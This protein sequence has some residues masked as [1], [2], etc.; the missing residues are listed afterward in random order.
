MPAAS[1]L[2]AL[3]ASGATSIVE[4][5]DRY[6]QARPRT[7][8][9]IV[10]SDLIGVDSEKLDRLFARLA[11]QRWRVVL[12]HIEDPME[13]DPADLAEAHEVLEI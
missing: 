8:V 10:V 3:K 1:Y 13:A 4:S 12:I 9:L 5:V 2:A 11:N 6:A 7:G